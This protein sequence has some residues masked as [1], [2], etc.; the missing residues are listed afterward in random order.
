MSNTF[1]YKLTTESELFYFDFSQVLGDSETIS[2]ANCTVEVASGTDASPSSIKSGS[3]VI[4]LAQVS[5]RILGG[6]SGATYRLITT[7]TTSNSN[8]YTTVGYLPV[9][10]PSEV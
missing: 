6:V 10:S 1:S 9:Y 3:M 2:T 7:I 8:T 5:Q 4:S